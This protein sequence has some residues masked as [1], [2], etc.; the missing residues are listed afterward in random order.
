MNDL[1]HKLMQY[2]T[3]ADFKNTKNQSKAM[4]FNKKN[5]KN[6]KANNI[7]AEKFKLSLKTSSKIDCKLFKTQF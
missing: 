4:Q 5:S 7:I 3:I 1:F 6:Q 2:F